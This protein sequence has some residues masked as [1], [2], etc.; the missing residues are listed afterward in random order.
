MIYIGIAVA[1]FFIDFFLKKY[2]DRKYARKVQH[3][4][5][6]NKV[7]IEKY[8][9]EGATLNLL[10]KKPK[11]MTAI[12]TVVLVCLAIVYAF[13][14]K[15]PGRE[16][17]KIGIAMV[18]GGGMSNLYDRYTKKHVVDYVR[19]NFGPKRLRKI[20]FN[21][22]DF[23]IFAGAIFAVLSSAKSE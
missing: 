20:I 6:K 9:N 17:E 23:F 8:Y 4:R 7:M 1:V 2:I 18:L 21:V 13:L 22:S 11:V 12:H 15:M 14:L 5:L 10:A 16:K 19:F 3:P